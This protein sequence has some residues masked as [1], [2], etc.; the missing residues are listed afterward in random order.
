MAI[1]KVDPFR[2]FAAMQ[3]RMNRLFGN[4]YLRDED[5][6]FRG[7][8]APAVDIFETDNHD[9]VVRAEL[10][11]MTRDDIEVSV[12]NSTLVLKGEKKFDAEVKEEHYR[13][14]ERTYGTFHRSFSLPNTVDTNKVSA[15]YKNGVLTV[16][17]PFK[18]EAKPRTINVEVAG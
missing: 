13:R 9:L 18:E 2:E 10:P 16:K 5:T 17:L 3:D 8:W 11:G 15:D 4:V 12:E 14:V 1:V 7:T 6:G